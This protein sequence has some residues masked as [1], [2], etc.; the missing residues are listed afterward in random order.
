MSCKGSEHSVELKVQACVESSPVVCPCPRWEA[1]WMK[2]KEP[3]GPP[4][5]I[6]SNIILVL[7]WFPPWPCASNNQ[8]VSARIG[9]R[10]PGILD[11]QTQQHQ[12][13]GGK[14]KEVTSTNVLN[15][16]RCF[17]D[18]FF[19]FKLKVHKNQTKKPNST[20]FRLLVKP[21]ITSIFSYLLYCEKGLVG[22]GW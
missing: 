14:K 17:D 7:L 11:E 22:A 8:P 2:H 13:Q 1:R 4:P 12:Q 21:W 5:H 18:F 9:A 19:F 15:L 6:S 10:T 3:F 16:K 20:L